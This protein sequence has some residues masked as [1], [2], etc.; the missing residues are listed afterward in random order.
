MTK[1][2]VFDHEKVEKI[3]RCG[4]SAFFV[5]KVSRAVVTNE[6]YQGQKFEVTQILKKIYS[7]DMDDRSRKAIE[8][9]LNKSRKDILETS[10]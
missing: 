4:S 9:V 8:S 1:F 3:D 10:L 5:V 2:F 7:S 6:S